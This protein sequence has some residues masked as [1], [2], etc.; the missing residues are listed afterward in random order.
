VSR[1]PLLLTVIIAGVLVSGCAD[2][3]PE[4]EGIRADRA[5]ERAPG[6]GIFHVVRVTGEGIRLR[7]EPAQLE[8]DAG[9]AV[10]FVQ[11]RSV[12]VSVNFEPTGL[13]PEAREWAAEAGLSRGP[14]LTDPG[15]IYEVD[16]ADAPPAVYRYL[17]PGFEDLEGRIEVAAEDDD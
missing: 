5:I 9:D 4:A 12:P 7:F 1:L 2:A 16:F 11:T 14:L 15:A 10:R 13:P 8:I 3:P 6:G 17:A